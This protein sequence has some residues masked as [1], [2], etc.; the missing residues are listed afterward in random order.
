MTTLD[1]TNCTRIRHDNQIPKIEFG[2]LCLCKEPARQTTE[3]NL[4]NILV[5]EIPKRNYQDIIE[6]YIYICSALHI[7][8]VFT[9]SILHVIFTCLILYV[10]FTCLL[11]LLP[12]SVSVYIKV[13]QRLENLIM[14]KFKNLSVRIVSLLSINNS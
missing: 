4:I 2:L 14:R 1:S 5:Q 12:V 11:F 3:S 8:V 9:C 7:H 6:S 13:Y 10:T